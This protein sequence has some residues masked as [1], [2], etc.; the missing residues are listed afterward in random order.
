MVKH[1][2][3]I[4]LHYFKDYLMATYLVNDDYLVS[5]IKIVE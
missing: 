3:F 1:Y 4:K 2:L 5:D